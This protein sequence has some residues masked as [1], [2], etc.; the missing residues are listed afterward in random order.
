MLEIE[1]AAPRRCSRSAR[2]DLRARLRGGDGGARAPRCAERE[3]ALRMLARR[4]DGEPVAGDDEDWLLDASGSCAACRVPHAAMLEASV[5]YRALARRRANAGPRRAVTAPPRPLRTSRGTVELG[6]RPWLMGIVNAT[7]D[8]FSDA[9]LHQTL[10][11]RVALAG[12][13]LRSRRAI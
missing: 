2:L 9:G 3:R 8:S 13:L 4:Q 7:P 5:C 11:E 10:E 12:S 6:G 1:P